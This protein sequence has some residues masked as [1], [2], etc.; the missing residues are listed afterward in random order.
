MLVRFRDRADAGRVLADAVAALQLGDPVVLALPRGGVPVAVPV[1]A[2]L[3][4]P[5][6]VVVAC[7]IGAPGSPEL[8][9]GAAVEDGL[10]VWNEGFAPDD[11]AAQAALEEVRRRIAAFRDGRQLTELADRDVVLVDD[12]LATGITAEAATRWVRQHGPNRIVVAAPVGAADTV[13]RLGAVADEVVCP[14]QPPGFG[15][16]GSW[17]DD[18]RQTG[19]AEVKRSLGRG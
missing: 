3:R 16:V 5:L 6:D 9:A 4:A 15:A 2:T 10:I 19:D 8:G 1:A 18:F 17:Y 14:V 12:G 11:K 13:G 7:K